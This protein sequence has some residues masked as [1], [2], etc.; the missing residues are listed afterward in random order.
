MDI[1]TGAGKDSKNLLGLKDNQEGILSMAE[2]WPWVILIKRIRHYFTS[3]ILKRN[4]V[5]IIENH[6][7]SRNLYDNWLGKI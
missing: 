4:P 7:I 6:V 5:H 2:S 1:I 3:C